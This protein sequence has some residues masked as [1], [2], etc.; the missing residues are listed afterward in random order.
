MAVEARE[1]AIKVSDLAPDG[2]FRWSGRFR[3]AIR[4][5]VT[6]TATSSRKTATRRRNLL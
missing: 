2:G 1:D 4:A 6:H 3:Q 5:R